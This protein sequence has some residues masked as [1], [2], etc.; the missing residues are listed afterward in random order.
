MLILSLDSAGSGCGACLW[1][2]GK[3]LAEASE[4]MERG[5]DQRLMPL[6]EQVMQ[7]GGP[8]YNDLD[9][10]AVTRG[11]GSFTGIRIGLAAARGIGLAQNKPVIGIDRFAVYRLHVQFP[12]KS[13]LVVINSKREEL[14]CRFYPARGGSMETLPMT[15]DQIAAF[16]ERKGETAV[17]GDIKPEG[18]ADFHRL[19]EKETVLAAALAAAAD[20]E[21]PI[22]LPRPLYI[23]PPDVTIE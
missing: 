15:P 19:N 20:P 8:G 13:L 7:K 22:F 1:R 23:R 18:V 14:F 21:D 12:N 10:I 4:S 3:V 6:I 16:I 9:R 5:Q 2:G 11:P 17:T